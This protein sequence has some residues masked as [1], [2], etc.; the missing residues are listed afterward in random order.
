MLMGRSM[1]RKMQVLRELS[2]GIKMEISCKAK[3]FGKI[4]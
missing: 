4:T 3:L 2:L 1:P